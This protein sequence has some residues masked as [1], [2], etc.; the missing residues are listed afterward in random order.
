M[1]AKKA[2]CK[3]CLVFT[4]QCPVDGFEDG[5]LAMTFAQLRQLLDL[6]MASDWSAYLADYG[7]PASRYVRVKP[8]V[9]IG[10]LE[11]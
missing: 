10:L 8:N 9:A 6:V 7:R 4:A 11:K 3:E 5:T 1:A 2:V